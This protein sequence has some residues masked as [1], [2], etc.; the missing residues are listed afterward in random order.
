M[1]TSDKSHPKTMRAGKWSYLWKNLVLLIML[2]ITTVLNIFLEEIIQPSSLVFVYLI[3]TIAGAIYFGTWAAVFSFVGGFLIFDFFFVPP[4]Y[5]L[6][7]AAPQDIY[8]VVLYFAVAGTITYLIS[9]VRRQNKALKDRLD[10][11]ALIEDMS[12][13]YLDLTPLKEPF[14]DTNIP[15]YVRRDLMNQLGKIAL[16]YAT[17]IIDSPALVFFPQEDG[18][19]KLWGK[20]SLDLEIS[21]E[22]QSA[23]DWTYRSG[24]ISGAGALNHPRSSFFFLPLKSHEYVIGVLGIRADL[25]ALFPEQRRILGAIS[26]L[27]SLVAAR[28]VD[29]KFEQG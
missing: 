18:T 7:I 28:W 23:A 25:K 24:E 6:H 12:L 1:E 16:R 15:E 13:D 26:N 9:I 10:R 20:S 21:A 27:T 3:N 22:E 2:A 8:N 29:L 19:L 11:T 14:A 5:S 17:M 4:Y